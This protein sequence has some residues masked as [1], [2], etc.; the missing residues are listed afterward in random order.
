MAEGSNT[1][2]LVALFLITFV[3]LPVSVASAERMFFF[4]FCET[5]RNLFIVY[6]K[7][8]K[9]DGQEI[10]AVESDLAHCFGY[11]AAQRQENWQLVVNILIYISC[12]FIQSKNKFPHK[13][14]IV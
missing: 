8:G 7:S 12:S 6:K 9:V 4:F 13:L 1:F 5:H 2:P 3:W 11:R 10:N 14:S